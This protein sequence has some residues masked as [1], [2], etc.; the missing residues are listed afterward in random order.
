MREQ[1]E[2]LDTL[3]NVEPRFLRNRNT[4]LQKRQENIDFINSLIDLDVE[5][6]DLDDPAVLKES[7]KNC[8]KAIKLI[9]G[10]TKE[11][12]SGPQ[13]ARQATPKAK[14][15]NRVEEKFRLRGRRARTSQPAEVTE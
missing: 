7:L 2:Q 6:L 4:E 5:S 9:A 14:P 8:I 12:L 10:V 15:K 11:R 3:P 1:P 13:R